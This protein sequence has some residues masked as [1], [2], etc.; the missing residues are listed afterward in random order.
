[1]EFYLSL[2]GKQISIPPSPRPQPPS[3]VKETTVPY[4]GIRLYLAYIEYGVQTPQ[5]RE[6]LLIKQE[7]LALAFRMGFLWLKTSP[8]KYFLVLITSIK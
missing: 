8:A 1:M 7:I 3:P 5:K 2:K 6:R 4:S